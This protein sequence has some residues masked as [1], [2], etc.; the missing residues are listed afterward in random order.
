M[1]ALCRLLSTRV[2]SPSP[3]LLNTAWENGGGSG[4]NGVGSNGICLK[5]RLQLQSKRQ[6]HTANR[7]RTR[8]KSEWIEPRGLGTTTSSSSKKRSG[9]SNTSALFSPISFHKTSVL[10]TIEENQTG[11]YKK[12]KEKKKSSPSSSTPRKA[13]I[14][15]F[16]FN[17][18]KTKKQK[19]F[20]FCVSNLNK[21]WAL[22]KRQRRDTRT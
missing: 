9:K 18:L 3:L 12:K 5:W 7:R 13:Q 20:F 11:S 22:M 2:F 1:R 16:Y 8:K 4:G 10:S 21:K 17:N 15:P 14:S 19:L 6:M